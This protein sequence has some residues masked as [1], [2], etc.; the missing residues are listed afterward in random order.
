M[1]NLGKDVS[2]F[3]H[4]GHALDNNSND[5]K[6][7]T[8]RWAHSNIARKWAVDLAIAVLSKKKPAECIGF[9]VHHKTV[10]LSKHTATLTFRLMPKENSE[11][12]GKDK[13]VLSI[14]TSQQRLVNKDLPI[15]QYYDEFE[16]LGK[17]YMVSACTDK[18]AG[19]DVRNSHDKT[20]VS[21]HYTI[22]NCMQK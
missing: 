10:N 8:P 11:T 7:K 9:I 14:N 5:P 22:S 13:D 3:F 15:R 4:G 6:K 2:K 21:R 19:S 20:K 18:Y 12:N 16:Y 1:Q 17:H